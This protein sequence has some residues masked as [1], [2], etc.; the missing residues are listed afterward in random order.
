MDTNFSIQSQ[1]QYD[2]FRNHPRYKIFRMISAMFK[3]DKTAEF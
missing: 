1:L 3:T 2:N